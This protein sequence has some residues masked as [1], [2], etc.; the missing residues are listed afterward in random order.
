MDFTVQALIDFVVAF[1]LGYV[2]PNI[3]TLLIAFLAVGFGVSLVHR[4]GDYLLR[5]AVRAEMNTDAQISRSIREY[6]EKQ[7]S[8]DATVQP[9]PRFHD[10]AYREY[11]RAGLLSKLSK[12]SVEELENLYLYMESVNEAGRRQE[13]LAYGPSAAYPN[14]HELRLENLTYVNDTVRNV[15]LPYHERLRDIK[16]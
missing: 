6:C 9:M 12:G 13:D 15:V 1:F 5:S 8:S 10:S 2:V 7:F 4:R 11:K 3:V 14:A 16:L